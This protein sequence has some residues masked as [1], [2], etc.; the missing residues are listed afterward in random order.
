MIELTL[1]QTQPDEAFL[2]P[3]TIEITMT[4][5]KRRVIVT[6]KDKETILTIRSAE[7]QTIVV[8][9]DEAI[10]KEIVN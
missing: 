10:L 4:T 9:P 8:D 5:G 1:R 2:Q 6:P 3:V 7:P